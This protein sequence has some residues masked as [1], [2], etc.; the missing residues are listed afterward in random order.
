MT[1]ERLDIV[2]KQEIFVKVCES[3]TCI[4]HYDNNFG[5]VR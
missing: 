1:L 3:I 5:Y 2:I 4:D